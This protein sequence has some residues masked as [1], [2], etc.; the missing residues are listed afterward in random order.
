MIRYP[1]TALVGQESLKTALLLNAVEPGIGGVLIS[2][3]KGTAKST[4]ARGLAA[5]LPLQ[6]VVPGCPFRCDPASPDPTCSHCGGLAERPSARAGVPFVDLPLGATEDRVVGTLDFEKALR[7][8]R[9]AFQPGLLAA[10]NRGILYI[11]EV[12]LLPD[13]LVD[14]LLDAAAMG[15]NVVQREGVEVVHRARFLL[16]GTMNPEEGELR[17]QFLDRF[18]LMVEV[19]GPRDPEARVEVVRRRIAFDAN[20]SAFGTT[21]AAEQAALAARIA[22][23]RDRLPAVV[24]DEGLL[25]LIARLCCEFGVDGLRADIVLHKTAR[26]MA[27]LDGRNLVTEAD[28]RR[29]A[30]LVLPHR[31]RRR[32]FEKPG[33]D[34]DRLE[35]LRSGGRPAEPP[36]SDGHGPRPDA[37]P[38][39]DELA[40]S[41]G[42]GNNE[43]GDETTGAT[44]EAE[45]QLFAPA[46]A[47]QARPIELIPSGRPAAPS[48]G[49]RDAKAAQAEG[50]GR[51]IRVVPD[52]TP[53]HLALDAT[54]RSAARNGIWADGRPIILRSDLHGKE[55]SGRSSALVLFL[56]DASGSMA[57]RRRMEAV[58]G[59]ALSLLRDAYEQRDRVALI[60]FRGPEAELVLP[61]T[62]SV[63]RVEESLRSLPTGGR[64]PLAHALR[65]AG[66]VVHRAIKSDPG[67]LAMPVL[68]TDGKAN[69]ALPGEL[70]DPWEQ[71][72][73]EAA[74]LASAG[75]APLVLDTDAGFVR[76]GRAAELAAALGAE[77]LPLEGLT[78]EA[79][80]LKIRQ[81]RR[82]AGP[83]ARPIGRGPEPPRAGGP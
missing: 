28:V 27:S 56:V 71:A 70:G 32:P 77:Y 43:D 7:E 42:P 48:P 38:S 1:F 33:L 6:D 22:E 17:P 82:S 78:A 69:V 66:E 31:R 79:I 41:G 40:P 10:A 49:R 54:L 4:A 45:D 34:R 52:E 57:A 76:V 55:R 62:G 13:H 47:V 60:A 26:A 12:N 51:A 29:S 20:P 58:K 16:V 53:R 46:M 63:E 80:A 81:H 64:T 23:A 36:G 61:P 21:W 15:V 50:R 35:D 11:D 5:L 75:V 68:L 67:S 83:H 72:M 18:V 65:L 74:I 25:L 30:E 37:G 3:E 14:L 2:G 8:G 39:G 44:T 19:T 9:R 24:L 73:E 59:A